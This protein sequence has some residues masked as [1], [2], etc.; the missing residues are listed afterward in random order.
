MASDPAESKYEEVTD[1]VE[2]SIEY[3]LIDSDAD[4]VSRYVLPEKLLIVA[5]VYS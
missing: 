4:R 3:R 1:P 2:K 5:M